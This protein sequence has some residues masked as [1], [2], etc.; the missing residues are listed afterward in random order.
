MGLA[1]R[2][3]STW[4]S[5]RLRPGLPPWRCGACGATLTFRTWLVAGRWQPRHDPCSASHL[6]A[7]VPVWLLVSISAALFVSAGAV[8]SGTVRLPLAWGLV[9]LLLMI[10]VIDL[11]R[12]LILNVLTYPGLALAPAFA[13][14]WPD[15]GLWRSLAGG[16][17]ALVIF[18]A[19]LRLRRGGLGQG[20]LKLAV[21]IGLYLGWPQVLMA[22][23][24]AF[25]LGGIV[26]VAILLA[27][28]KRSSTFSYGPVLAAG[29]VIVLLTGEWLLGLVT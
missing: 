1:I 18:T 8:F 12:G 23:A 11:E 29:A 24:L 13:L 7:G 26:A 21:L 10:A 25:V 27:G 9:A 15:L 20:D 16:T 14:L 4:L 5:Y 2:L 19:L 22:L 17:A 28:G 6:P 3:A